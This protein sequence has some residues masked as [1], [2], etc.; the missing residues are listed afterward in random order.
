MPRV[1]SL[2]ASATEIVSALGFGDHLVGCSH[3]CDFPAAVRALPALTKP[4]LSIERPSAAIDRDVKA[5]LEQ[6]LSVYAVDADRL[7]AL[8]PDVIVTQTQCAVCAVSLDDVNRALETWT[9]YPG[10]I[11]SLEPNALAD[12]W[13]DIQRVADAL[14]A[15][16]AGRDLVAR[17]RARMQAVAARASDLA[18]RPRV[19]T[20]E[21]IEPLMVAGNWVPE[22]IDMAGGED[23]LGVAG[24]HSPYLSWDALQTA[25]PDVI[26]TMPCGFDIARTRQE[27]PALTGDARWRDLAAVRAGRVYLADGNQYFNRPG[28][29]VVESLEILAEILHPECFD[30]GHQ[31]RGWVRW[32][33]E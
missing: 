16:D 17:L 33:D 32:A 22:L 12:I 5:L 14:G 7:R 24:Q 18:P 25:A 29:R 9:D 31:G 15:P 28:P 10:R 1:V 13:T 6:A 21:W 27:M 3:E 11:V 26:V 8:R 20:I 23:R 4:K 19:A 2:I 30:F